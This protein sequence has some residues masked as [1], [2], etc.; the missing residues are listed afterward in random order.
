MERAEQS[1]MVM[2]LLNLAYVP[3]DVI[4]SLEDFKPGWQEKLTNLMKENQ[5][6][7]TEKH[8]EWRFQDEQMEEE[9]KDYYM[10]VRE[11][12]EVVK[13]DRADDQVRYEAE[14][15]KNLNLKED[16]K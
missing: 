5:A 8:S 2:F 15:E 1:D 14:V 6:T 10:D 9:Y 12:N 3:D 13:K 7:F 4:R 16:K 11:T